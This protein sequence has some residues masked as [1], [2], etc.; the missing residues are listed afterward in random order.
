[1]TDIER[2]PIYL[3]ER[4]IHIPEK[5][6]KCVHHRPFLIRKGRNCLLYYQSID[7][8]ILHSLLRIVR[9]TFLYPYNGSV[10]GEWEPFLIAYHKPS[11][12]CSVH[13][14]MELHAHHQKKCE[15]FSNLFYS[16]KDLKQVI[17]KVVW[18]YFR[19]IVRDR[20]DHLLPISF[21]LVK[22]SIL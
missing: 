5:L 12:H 8:T 17:D 22:R 11:F 4:W 1:M 16:D 20:I 9:A 21:Q 19:R 18:E 3:L 2:R 15:V 13:L 7:A 6:I 14:Q 10:P